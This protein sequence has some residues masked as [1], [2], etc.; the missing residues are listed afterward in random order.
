MVLSVILWFDKRATSLDRLS[1]PTKTNT[2]SVYKEQK[3]E[4]AV[5]HGDFVIIL[6]LL[7][8]S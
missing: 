6:P 4:V 2:V 3:G 5:I 1:E 7:E 8:L